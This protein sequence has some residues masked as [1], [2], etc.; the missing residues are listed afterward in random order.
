MRRYN[1]TQTGQKIRST[2]HTVKSKT[3]HQTKGSNAINLRAKGHF[4][5]G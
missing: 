3:I 5:F 4:I 1:S 2:Q